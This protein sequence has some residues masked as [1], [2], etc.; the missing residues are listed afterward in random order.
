MTITKK[1]KKILHLITGLDTGGAEMMLLKTLPGLQSDFENTVCCIKGRGPVG[2]LL[3][4]SGVSVIYL[5]LKSFLDWRI[6][7]RF[8]DAVAHT[9]PDLVVTYLIHADLFGRILGKIFGVKQIFCS[10]RVKLVQ[11]KYL[12]L[13]LIDGLTS[14]LVNHYHFNSNVVYLLYKKYFFLP[15]KKCT[16]IPN[17]LDVAKYQISADRGAAKLKE[18]GFS[19]DQ[20]LFGCLANLR[21]QKGHSYLLEAFQKIQTQHPT[22]KLL[23][24]G[25]GEERQRLELLTSKLGIEKNV[26]FLGN[27][28]DVPE[29]LYILDFFVF[30][31]LFEGMSNALMEAMA[32]GL[33]IIA[34]DILENKEIIKHEFSGI[35]VPVKN[36]EALSGAMIDLV[37]NHEKAVLLG[38]NAKKYA[39]EEF[40]I[41]KIIARYRDLFSR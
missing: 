9:N 32:S 21:A 15:Q 16:I 39:R 35:L 8:R 7:G 38:E 2:K 27:R 13:L 33:P 34:T 1:P 31:T 11:A 3:E 29:L 6:I 26:V 40:S 36:A 41:E 22:S 18:L 37:N 30:P 4:N 5:E 14:F 24:I 25:D 10:V 23:L 19:R 17:G 12:P 20:I 28:N